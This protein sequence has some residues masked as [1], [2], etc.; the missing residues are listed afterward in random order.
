MQLTSKYEYD[1]NTG[2]VTRI[3]D[4]NNVN[5]STVYDAVG[6]PTLVKAAE[7]TPAEKHT[8]TSYLDVARRVIVK[9]NL[10][11]VDDGKLVSIQ[12][13]DQLGRVRLARTLEDASTQDP[14]N[15]RQGIKVQT[16]Y[17]V[18]M[19]ADGTPT[20]LTYQLVSNPYRAELSSQANGES[21]M[22]WTLATSQKDGRRTET[23]TF[24]GCR[25]VD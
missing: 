11:T 21:T 3:T 10:N 8:I 18:G 1:F 9:S 24:A 16:R 6:H 12:H 17:K 19:L 22:G 7:G 25:F 23:E 4:P 13:F 20:G 15:E 14:T 2:M 5:V